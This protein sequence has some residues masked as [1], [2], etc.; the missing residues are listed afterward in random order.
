MRHSIDSSAHVRRIP[1]IGLPPAPIRIL[2]QHLGL[3]CR[4]ALMSLC[5]L[6]LSSCLFFFGTFAIFCAGRVMKRFVPEPG[7]RA[8]A[9]VRWIALHQPHDLTDSSGSGGA[10][11]TLRKDEIHFRPF[12]VLRIQH[13]RALYRSHLFSRR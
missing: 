6:A 9:R 12:A 13:L 10:L 1:P 11:I 2:P 8:C 7:D 5:I 3:F 4:R